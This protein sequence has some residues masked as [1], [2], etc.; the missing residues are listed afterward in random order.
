MDE[1]DCS[2]YQLPKHHQCACH[3]LNLISTVDAT[4]ANSNETYK[5]VSRAASAKCW[6]LWNKSGRSTIAAEL[7]KRE[8]KLQLIRLNDT[9]WNSLFLEVEHVLRIIKDS[10]EGAI[11]AVAI[12]LKVPMLNPA[13]LAFLTE[14]VATMSPISKALNIMQTEADVHMGWLMPTITLLTVKL[15]HL[16]LSSKFCQPLID[17]IQGR[18]QRQFGPMLADPELIAAAILLPKFRISW[19]SN[20]D[21][22]KLGLDYIKTHLE[23]EPVQLPGNNSS[24]SEDN[25]FSVMKTNIQ[26]FHTA[27]WVLGQ[28]CH[29]NGCS[30]VSPCSVQ[31][32]V[33]VKHTLACLSSM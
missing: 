26:E 7:I 6:A 27:R 32:V 21:M 4:K 19:T 10:G 31:F 13:E 17:V 18:I 11:R 8:C 25:Y 5:K 23:Q 9:R 15:G 20:E 14:F 2:E 30:Q 16:R 1:D 12:A 22:L 29:Y 28:Q 33:K 3:T 24:S